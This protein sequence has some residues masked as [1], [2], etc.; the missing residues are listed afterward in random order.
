[1]GRQQGAR[2]L[3]RVY[4]AMGETDSNSIN[5]ISNYKLKQIPAKGPEGAD[6]RIKG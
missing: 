5:P 1:M 2:R 6:I 4:T 3:L